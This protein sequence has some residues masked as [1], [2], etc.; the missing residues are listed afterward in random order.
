MVAVGDDSGLKYVGSWST[1]G[2]EFGGRGGLLISSGGRRLWRWMWQL[3]FLIF[4]CWISFFFAFFND[5]FGGG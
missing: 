2:S 5:G 3:G 1:V 4:F